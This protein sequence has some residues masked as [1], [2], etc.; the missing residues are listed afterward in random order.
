MSRREG[1]L[2]IGIFHPAIALV[3]SCEPLNVALST[4]SGEKI[5]IA[6]KEGH[7]WAKI[8]T[9]KCPNFG[10]CHSLRCKV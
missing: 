7:F 8:S 5:D 10:I 4:P 1:V 6:E 2:H 3:L 9:S